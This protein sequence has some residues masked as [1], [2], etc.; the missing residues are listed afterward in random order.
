MPICR[1]CWFL[2]QKPRRGIVA[3]HRGFHKHRRVRLR[4]CII[5]LRMLGAGQLPSSVGT[6]LRPHLCYRHTTSVATE[7]VHTCVQDGCSYGT[8]P[9][10]FPEQIAKPS[11]NSHWIIYM[12]A[13]RSTDRAIRVFPAQVDTLCR[14]GL[15]H[16]IHKSGSS[17]PSVI[18]PHAPL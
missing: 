6:G 2:G 7:K 11:S 1:L 14:F 4:V 8:V 3:L 13:C 5:R 17:Q 10:P 18:P 9:R 15:W 16:P 12:L